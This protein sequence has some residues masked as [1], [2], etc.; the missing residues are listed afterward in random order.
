MVQPSNYYFSHFQPVHH[1]MFPGVDHLGQLSDQNSINHVKGTIKS[2]IK[3]YSLR[4]MV[5]EQK[6]EVIPEI[7]VIF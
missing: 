3:K 7:R 2:L 4:R 5:A 1:K 6:E